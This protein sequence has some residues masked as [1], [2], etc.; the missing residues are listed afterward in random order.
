MP[1]YRDV[2]NDLA[3][4]PPRR[5]ALTHCGD[6]VYLWPRAANYRMIR[7]DH[8]PNTKLCR[9]QILFEFHHTGRTARILARARYD[10][11]NRVMWNIFWEHARRVKAQRPKEVSQT[12]YTR[13]VA[14]WVVAAINANRIAQQSANAIRNYLN[15]P[16]Q[17]LKDFIAIL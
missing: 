6:G 14:R 15:N 16:P 9:Y 3:A 11:P 8:A 5:W 10:E 12:E 13:S 2:F 4:N 17:N 7:A 1:Y